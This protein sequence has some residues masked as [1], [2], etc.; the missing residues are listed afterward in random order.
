V[1][2]SPAHAGRF[3]TEQPRSVLRGGCNQAELSRAGEEV[4]TGNGTVGG[5]PKKPTPRGKP[6][7]T[8]TWRR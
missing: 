5:F 1:P 6:A 4:L 2:C 8:L 7:D 3:S